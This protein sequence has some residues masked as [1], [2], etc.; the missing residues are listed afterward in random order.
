M[1]ISTPQVKVEWTRASEQRRIG[2]GLG[3][4]RTRALY[5]LGLSVVAPSLVLVLI[6]INPGDNQFTNLPKKKDGLGAHS[7]IQFIYTIHLMKLVYEKNTL[8]TSHILARTKTEKKEGISHILLRGHT[9]QWPKDLPLRMLWLSNS[10]NLGTFGTH[11]RLKLWQFLLF[12][13]AYE[14]WINRSWVTSTD[15]ITFYLSVLHKGNKHHT[16]N[17][18]TNVS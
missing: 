4:D 2:D 8:S 12:L 10:S 3:S 16:V 15:I 5:T 13:S 17:G 11:S 14:L 1:S 7:S 6:T 18:L 9:A